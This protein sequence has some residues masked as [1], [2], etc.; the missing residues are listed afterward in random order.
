MHAYI[1]AQ[2]HN[3]HTLWHTFLCGIE[4][5]LYNVINV[6]LNVATRRADKESIGKVCDREGGVSKGAP[7][8]IRSK[9]SVCKQ[10]IQYTD[11]AT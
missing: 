4:G 1:R 11:K 2:T 8:K 5:Y 6:T 9:R 7:I 10:G 3:A